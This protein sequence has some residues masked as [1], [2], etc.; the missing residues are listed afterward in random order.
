[1][2]FLAAAAGD[3]S[4]SS[5]PPTLAN[6]LLR[7]AAASRAP[8]HRLVALFSLLVSR[9]GFRPN[10]FSFST[11]LA[12]LADAGAAAVPHGRVL[13]ARA[14]ACGLALSSAH[15]LTSLL[16]LWLNGFYATVQ[17]AEESLFLVE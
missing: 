16:D 2:L 6:L 15:V 17:N 8:P 9:H 10:A 3:S 12:A 14:L 13:H 4:T 5:S 11:L 7:T 1:M